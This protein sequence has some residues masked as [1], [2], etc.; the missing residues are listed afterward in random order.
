MTN[1]NFV[2][3]VSAFGIL[4][5]LFTQFATPLFAYDLQ[6]LLTAQED[7]TIDKTNTLDIVGQV[8]KTEL[9]I[10]NL[11]RFPVKSEDFKGLSTKFS[12]FHPG[13]DIRANLGAE[14][15]PVQVGK[16]V[17][18]AYQ[19]GGYGNYVLIQHE[20]GLQTLYAHMQKKPSV[21]VGDKVTMDTVIGYVGSTGRSTGP[22]IHFEVYS[23]EKRVNPATILPEIPAE[24]G[25]IARAK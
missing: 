21:Q 22:H 12:F 15:N 10:T 25:L 13:Y 18:V 3:I 4:T 6:D 7:T 2:R 9:K 20:N 11:Y 23:G 8:D 16:V 19:I 14:I 24:A 1:K 17:E 5:I